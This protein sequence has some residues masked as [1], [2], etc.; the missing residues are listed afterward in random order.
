[1]ASVL[2]LL[3][4]LLLLLVKC[5][6]SPVASRDQLPGRRQRR[7]SAQRQPGREGAAAAAAARQP[8]Q[9]PELGRQPDAGGWHPRA[10]GVS[11]HDCN[12]SGCR[13]NL[14]CCI[15]VIRCVPA[16]PTFA[17]LGACRIACLMHDL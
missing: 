12:R 7:L 15:F 11:D 1:M 13:F 2:L 4:L 17:G 9:P 14:H 10:Q 6:L 5:L 16:S 3:L 8:Q